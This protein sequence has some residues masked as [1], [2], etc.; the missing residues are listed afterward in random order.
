MSAS[1]RGYGI[2]ERVEGARK[3]KQHWSLK[4]S[5]VILPWTSKEIKSVYKII[6]YQGSSYKL[7]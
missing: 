3:K 2:I 6:P 1:F 4:Y 5:G 7:I